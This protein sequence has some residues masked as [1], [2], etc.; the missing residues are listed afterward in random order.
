VGCCT[1]GVTN[2]RPSEGVKPDGAWSEIRYQGCMETKHAPQSSSAVDNDD[3]RAA[4]EREWAE[5]DEMY[6]AI[7]NPEDAERFLDDAIGAREDLIT[8]VRRVQ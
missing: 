7:T 5:I 3:R 6:R 8:S 1:S 2:A 4:A